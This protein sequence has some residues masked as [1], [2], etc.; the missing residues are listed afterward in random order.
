VSIFSELNQLEDI[1]LTDDYATLCGITQT[2]LE[3]YFTPDIQDLAQENGL[4]FE[5]A[6]AEMRKRYNGYRFSRRGETVYNPFSLLNTIKK[7]D[8]QHY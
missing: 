8:S 2:E 7:K 1:S 6:L 4:C 5:D 3:A